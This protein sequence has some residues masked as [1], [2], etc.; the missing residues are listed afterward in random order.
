MRSSSSIREA[1]EA[2]SGVSVLGG[3]ERP[4]CEAVKVKLKL[5]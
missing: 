1:A 2:R 5:S 3:L 4:L